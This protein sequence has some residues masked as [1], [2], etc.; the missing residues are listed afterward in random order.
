MLSVTFPFVRFASATKPF[1][2]F[3]LTKD[4]K[5]FFSASLEAPFLIK[6]LRLK[7]PSS[8]KQFLNVPLEVTLI[9]LQS[10]Q[11]VLVNAGIIPMVPVC[12]S[13]V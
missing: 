9:R 10:E 7:T 5:R 4:K 2:G 3:L 11:I 8:N 12:F 6:S 13:I 1:S